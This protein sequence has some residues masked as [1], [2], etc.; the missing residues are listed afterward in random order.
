M[1][2]TTYSLFYAME[3][4]IRSSFT[5]A[6]ANKLD[7]QI[8]DKVTTAILENDEVVSLENFWVGLDDLMGRNC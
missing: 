8:E 5:P 6:A 7:E 2:D 3:E 4:E 1:N